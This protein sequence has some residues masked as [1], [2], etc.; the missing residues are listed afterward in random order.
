M[1]FEI[2]V[3]GIVILFAGFAIYQVG[4]ERG[5]GAEHK[6]WLEH[7]ERCEKRGR[8]IGFS[9]GVKKA[10]EAVDKVIL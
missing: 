9:E 4:W 5:Y 3:I 6:G 7:G 10:K 1:G 8:S 2:V